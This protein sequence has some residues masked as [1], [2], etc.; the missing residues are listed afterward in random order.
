MSFINFGGL[1]A[2]WAKIYTDFIE[3]K[4]DEALNTTAGPRDVNRS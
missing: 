4:S 3:L 2:Y 1:I